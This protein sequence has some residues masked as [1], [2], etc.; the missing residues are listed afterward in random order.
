[1]TEQLRKDPQ[2]IRKDPQMIKKTT[3]QMFGK[4]LS[5][6]SLIL[7]IYFIADRPIWFQCEA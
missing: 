5:H 1:M 7:F 3:E 4:E 2:M 6:L